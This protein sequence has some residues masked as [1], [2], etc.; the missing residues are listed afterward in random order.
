MVFV[1]KLR[2]VNFRDPC[3]GWV[4]GERRN[5][6]FSGI[7]FQKKESNTNNLLF[8]VTEHDIQ[9]VASKEDSTNL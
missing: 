5:P 7:Y 9:H 4:G 6:T 2:L 1:D 3:C 8:G